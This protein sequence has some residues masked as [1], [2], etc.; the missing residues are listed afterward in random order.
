MYVVTLGDFCLFIANIR[1]DYSVLSANDG[2][3]TGS[4]PG[5]KEDILCGQRPLPAE[6]S[7]HRGQRRPL[8]KNIHGH[9]WTKGCVRFQHPFKCHFIL[10]LISRSAFS[11]F[12]IVTFIAQEYNSVFL[13]KTTLSSAVSGSFVCVFHISWEFAGVARVFSPSLEWR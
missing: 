6:E 5:V 7:P 9:S 8:D 4:K 3:F 10:S 11:L 13:H 1:F 12:L 2:K